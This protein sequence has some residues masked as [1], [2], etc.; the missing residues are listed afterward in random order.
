LSPLQAKHIITGINLQC[1]AAILQK[2]ESLY[3]LDDYDNIID[4]IS[5]ISFHVRFKLPFVAN[6]NWLCNIIDFHGQ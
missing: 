4:C 3:E 6:D 5:S 1:L 2:K